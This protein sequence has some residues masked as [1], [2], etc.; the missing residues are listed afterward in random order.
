MKI[1]NIKQN[2]FLL[3]ANLG[4]SIFHVGDLSRIWNIK[5]RQNLSTTLNRYVNSGLMYRL[6]RGLYALKKVENLDPLLL[7]AKAINSYC[8][9]G[10]ETILL[11]HGAIFQ[12]VNYFTFVGQRT[13]RF[14]IVSY[15][16]YCRQL[17]DKF[18]FNDTGID[19]TGKFNEASLERAVADI[20]Y[21]N[22]HYHFDNPKIINQVKLKNILQT[23]YN[24]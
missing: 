2:R 14:E 3:L 13:K 24:K 1:S 9:L 4:E 11:K 7:G 23:V 8:Y 6:Y 10:G 12:Q 18:L 20:L 17:K 15:K 22:P 21:V 16:Y 5:N 19:K